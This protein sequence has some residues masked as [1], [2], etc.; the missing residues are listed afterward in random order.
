MAAGVEVVFVR[1][2]YVV[3]IFGKSRC[4]YILHAGQ[5]FDISSALINPH[6]LF[7]FLFGGHAGG[8]EHAQ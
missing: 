1:L 4:V 2:E 8:L 7:H 6:L 5:T 3:V